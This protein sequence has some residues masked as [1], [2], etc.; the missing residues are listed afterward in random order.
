MSRVMVDTNILIRFFGA[1][2]GTPM[3]T[4]DIWIAASAIQHDCPLFTQDAHFKN[5]PGLKL[6]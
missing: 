4:N 6:A 3:P 2:A 5:V 1:Q